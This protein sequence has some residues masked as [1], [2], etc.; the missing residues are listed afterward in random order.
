MSLTSSQK[1]AVLTRVVKY[2]NEDMKLPRLHRGQEIVYRL[3]V[4]EDDRIHCDGF[5]ARTLSANKHNHALD[6]VQP[7]LD[8]LSVGILWIAPQRTAYEDYTF[9]DGAQDLLVPLGQHFRETN[10]SDFLVDSRHPLLSTT[11]FGELSFGVL[12][13]EEVA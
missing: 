5:A 2:L 9:K 4:G 10:Y 12:Y 8:R 11:L 6:Q 1:I 3:T 13:E 7:R